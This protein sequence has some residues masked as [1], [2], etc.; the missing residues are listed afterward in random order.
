MIQVATDQKSGI[1]LTAGVSLLLDSQE[2]KPESLNIIIHFVA[3]SNNLS[4]LDMAGPIVDDLKCLEDGVYVYDAF[5]KTEVSLITSVLCALCDN[6]RAS[7]LLNHL[8]SRAKF[9]CRKCM[10]LPI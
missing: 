10:V 2:I 3:C 7:E 5:L 4:A 6:V 8:G 1:N 9:F